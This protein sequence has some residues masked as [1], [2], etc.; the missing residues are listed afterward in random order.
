MLRKERHGIHHVKQAKR[1]RSRIHNQRKRIEAS[2]LMLLMD[3]S[4]QCWFDNKKFCTAIDD[5]TSELFTEFSLLE[6]TVGCFK[7]LQKVIEIVTFLKRCM[8]T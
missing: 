1:R 5:V 4:P 3:G 6:T 2:G 8:L 7:V